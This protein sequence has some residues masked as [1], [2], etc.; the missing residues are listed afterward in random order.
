[1][2]DVGS[3]VA[4]LTADTS[5]FQKAIQN[6]GKQVSSFTERAGKKLDSF[7]KTIQ[8][9]GEG[10]KQ[11]G[12]KMSLFLT[13]PIV[14]AGLAGLKAAMDM[15]ATGAKFNTVFGEMTDEA[16][17]F[18]AKFQEL[19]PATRA[20]ARNMAS[21]I[22]DLLIPM[23]FARD[24]ATEM[25]GE[26]MHV[27]G[28]LQ[29]FN[30][31]THD[32]QR[33]MDAMNAALIGSYE[34]LT[35]LGIQLDVNTVKEKAVAMGLAAT[36]KEVTKQHQAQVALAEIYAQS[37]DALTAYTAENLDAGTKIKILTS[38]VIDIASSIFEKFIPALHTVIGVVE[39]WMTKFE[40]LDEGTQNMIL[41]VGAF[42]A[43]IGPLLIVVGTLITV[44]GM[45]LSPIGLV[46]VAIAGLGALIAMQEDPMQRMRDLLQNLQSRFGDLQPVID[47]ARQ[48]FEQV[49]S[50]IQI[51]IP[52]LVFI[53]AQVLSALFYAWQKLKVPVLELMRS[54]MDMWKAVRPIVMLLVGLVAGYLLVKWQIVFA[55]MINAIAGFIQFFRGV[56]GVISGIANIIVGIF[57]GN[58]SKIGE[59]FHQVFGGLINMIH[60]V[61]GMIVSPFSGAVQGILNIFR[62]ISWWQVGMDIVNGI[63]AGLG[64]LGSRVGSTIRNAVPSGIR[65]LIPGFA[66][67]VQNFAG[68]LAQINERGGELIGLP[69]GATVIPASLSQSMLDG[70]RPATAGVTIQNVTINENADT[71]RFFRELDR[72]TRDENIIG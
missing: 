24:E 63:V 27:A 37:G 52:I 68:G 42:V 10:M 21:G 66:S 1:M 48:A 20:Q 22:Q 23:G 15:E 51:L 6:A 59:G 40:E 28:A 64:S 69:Q 33:V 5:G 31:G 70:L 53:A 29:A 60:G 11:A 13:T 54:V 12:Q 43:A 18:I 49:R 45:L 19:T 44:F 2:F 17:K 55:A 25:T 9:V 71:D 3:I 4:R 50:A 65:N 30:S 41:K 32:T 38:R 8:N 62:G 72:R 26:F 47:F 34:P 39:G 16:D 57:T 46:A 36:T 56:L 35:S 14:G 7:K 67:G 61:I 58:F